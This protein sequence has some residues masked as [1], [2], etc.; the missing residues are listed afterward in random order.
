M[1]LCRAAKMSILHINKLLVSHRSAGR[2]GGE[3][4][5]TLS[6]PKWAIRPPFIVF[7]T[8]KTPDRRQD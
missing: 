2:R 3:K 1:V 8:R 6:L 7:K 5:V 4:L